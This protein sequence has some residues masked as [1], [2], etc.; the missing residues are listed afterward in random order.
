MLPQMVWLPLLRPCGDRRLRIRRNKC[1]H[2][3]HVWLCKTGY[4]FSTFAF[5]RVSSSGQMLSKMQR[6]RGSAN[7][8]SHIWLKRRKW[9]VTRCDFIASSLLYTYNV[10]QTLWNT[11]QRRK[12][13]GS[14]F[15][16]K[17]CIA[18]DTTCTISKR[19]IPFSLRL[20]WNMKNIITFYFH[21]WYT[22]FWTHFHI[23]TLNFR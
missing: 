6:V 2:F 14:S 12:W 21:S 20:T 3:Y 19:V 9:G 23:L 8:T 16:Y 13:R 11:S 10:H 18:E 22:L 4:S 5:H 7:N 17:E 15:S 1:Y